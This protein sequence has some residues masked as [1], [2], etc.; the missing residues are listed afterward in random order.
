MDAAD[1]LRVIFT[2]GDVHVRRVLVWVQVLLFMACDD[3]GSP[4]VVLRRPEWRWRAHED[5]FR[6]RGGR[7]AALARSIDRKEEAHLAK[8]GIS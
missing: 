5:S 7:I 8:P 4:V 2:V 1:W 6:L 3:Y